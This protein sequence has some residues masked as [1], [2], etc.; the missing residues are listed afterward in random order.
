MGPHLLAGMHNYTD[1]WTQEEDDIIIKI[2]AQ[3]GNRWALIADFLKGAP[4][5]AFR[6][7]SKCA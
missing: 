2:H 3:V 1:A 4:D 5:A 6:L 7:K